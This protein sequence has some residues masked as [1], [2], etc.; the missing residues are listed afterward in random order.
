MVK[1]RSKTPISLLVFL[2]SAIL[3]LIS[4][5]SI[6]VRASAVKLYFSL[7]KDQK[8]KTLVRLNILKVATKA[9][10]LGF[11]LLVF[12]P[13]MVMNDLLKDSGGGSTLD[14]HQQAHLIGRVSYELYGPSVFKMGNSMCHSG[15][16]HGSMEALLKEEG[17]SDLASKVDNICKAFSTNFGQFECYHG[18]GHGILAY[19]DY[20]LPLALKTCKDLQDE[21]SRTSCFGGV[22]MEN[23]MTSQGKGATLAHTTPWASNDPHF[24]CN[25]FFGD[26]KVQNQCYQMQT[27][28][29]LIM[30]ENDFNRVLEECLRAPDNMKKACFRSFG[31]DAAGQVLRDPNRIIELCQKVPQGFGYTEECVI[32]SLNVIIDFW[33]EN[34]TNQ[35]SEYCSKLQTEFKPIC[36]QTLADRLP[37]LF[38]DYS[39]QEEVCKTIEPQYQYLCQKLPK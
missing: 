7:F 29:M 36:Y 22:F 38:S 17:T 34:L 2:V 28:R 15:Y 3:I 24:P 39:K 27:S 35:A 19:E 4:I 10:D 33:G 6:K 14:C 31:R 12:D 9:K 16:Y 8:E 13:E 23:V 37:G 25:Y 5:S 20:D 18:I 11:W 26:F 32:G 21:F 1:K 30:F